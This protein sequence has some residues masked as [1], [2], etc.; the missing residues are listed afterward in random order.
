VA[1]EAAAE[2]ASETAAET[3]AEARQRKYFNI[4][5]HHETI[6]IFAYSTKR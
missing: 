2:A 4:L 6:G 5:L 3:A 1:S